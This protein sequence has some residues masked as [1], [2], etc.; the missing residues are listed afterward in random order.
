M[1][2]LIVIKAFQIL[3]NRTSDVY[4]FQTMLRIHFRIWVSTKELAFKEEAP[5]NHMNVYRNIAIEAEGEE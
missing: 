1:Y 4:L 3:E 2:N 5:S